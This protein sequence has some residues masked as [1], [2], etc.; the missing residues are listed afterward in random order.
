LSLFSEL[1]RRNVFKVAAAYVIVGWLL[2]QISDT[3]VPALRLP[4]WFHS[5]VAFLLIM[6]FPVAGDDYV[7]RDV[8]IFKA[9]V[10]QPGRIGI[11]G[12]LC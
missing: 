6:G 1:H 9:L 2:L 11:S 5:G 3:L 8:R 10:E 7:V 12:L 4:E